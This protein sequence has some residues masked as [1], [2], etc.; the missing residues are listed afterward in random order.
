MAK[1]RIVMSYYWEGILNLV[2]VVGILEDDIGAE[3]CLV[4]GLALEGGGGGGQ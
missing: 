3:A 2:S 1:T 4:N